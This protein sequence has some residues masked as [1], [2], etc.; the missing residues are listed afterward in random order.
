MLSLKE[1]V[2]Q[3]LQILERSQAWLAR[4]VGPDGRPIDP[5]L[6]NHYLTGRRKRPEW[7]VPRIAEVLGVPLD[8]LL[9][10][11]DKPAA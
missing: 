8:E 11:V 6:F 3:R 1:R 7:L 4:K 9:V 10:L 2:A 5:A